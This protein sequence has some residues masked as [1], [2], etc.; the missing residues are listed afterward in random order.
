MR[1]RCRRRAIT[2]L[3]GE[4]VDSLRAFGVPESD[5]CL[6]PGIE[7]LLDSQNADGSWGDDADI[8]K[9]CH[10]TWT[11]V[12]GLREFAWEDAGVAPAA[13]RRLWESGT[14]PPGIS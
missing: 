2:E 9:K 5:P 10:T 7:Y 4:F 8:F 13:L 3:L 14:H 6:W 11:A 12:D 1:G